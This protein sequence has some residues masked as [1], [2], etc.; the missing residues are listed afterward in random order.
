MENHS[1]L[2]DSDGNP[3]VGM[4]HVVDPSPY[5]WLFILFNTMEEAVRTDPEGRIVP[6][7]AK[8]VQWLD[9]TTLELQLREGVY[10]HNNQPFT[11]KDVN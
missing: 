2:M 1:E 7:L 11:S 9:D 4:I 5:N 3:P 10:Y 8:N 6:S